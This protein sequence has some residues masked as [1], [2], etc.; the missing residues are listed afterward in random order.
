MEDYITHEVVG[1]GALVDYQPGTWLSRKVKLPQNPERMKD[2]SVHCPYKI[3]SRT[4]AR[5]EKMTFIYT[6]SLC[7][8]SITLSYKNEFCQLSCPP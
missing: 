2:A 7:C 1:S 5:R 3:I 4:S 6:L 8:C